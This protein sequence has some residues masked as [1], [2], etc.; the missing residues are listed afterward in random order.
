MAYVFYVYFMWS[1][2][3]RDEY[4][5]NDGVPSKRTKGEEDE[6]IARKMIIKRAAV[7]KG[8]ECVVQ[9]YT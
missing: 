6:R 7:G 2:C 8:Q 5:R 3:G 1:K 4:A 9:Y